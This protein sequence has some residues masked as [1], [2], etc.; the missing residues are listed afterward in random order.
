M[1]APRLKPRFKPVDSLY[2]AALEAKI[3]TAIIL[4]PHLPDPGRNRPKTP[5]SLWKMAVRTLPRDPRRGGAAK[6][7]IKN[8]FKHGMVYDGSYSWTAK[9]FEGFG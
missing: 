7:K 9:V 1:K 3:K 8:R 5:D 2:L 4:P 6:N